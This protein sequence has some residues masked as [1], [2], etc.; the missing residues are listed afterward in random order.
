[1]LSWK[2]SIVDRPTNV[3]VSDQVRAA[4]AEAAKRNREIEQRCRDDGQWVVGHE[5]FLDALAE[6][7]HHR[8]HT[9]RYLVCQH[10]DSI[11]VWSCFNGPDVAL[12]CTR[13]ACRQDLQ[14]YMEWVD[15]VPYCVLC[16]DRTPGRLLLEIGCAISAG[17]LISICHFDCAPPEAARRAPIR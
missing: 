14:D 2:D 4:A 8:L 17:H 10:S 15:T 9:E 11:T 1:M 12:A 5:E 16:D 3:W 13:E 6:A 7:F